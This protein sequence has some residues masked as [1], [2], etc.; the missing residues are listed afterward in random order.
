MNTVA[1]S[2]VRYSSGALEALKYLA[3]AS[4]VAD[5]VNKALFDSALTWLV[6]FGRLAFPIF[7]CLVGYNLARPSADYAKILRRLLVVAAIAT[8]FHPVIMGGAWLPLNVLTTF[9]VAVLIAWAIDARQY[10]VAIA[11][12]L[13]LPAFVDYQWSGVTLV[14]YAW[15]YA[16]NGTWP[17]AVG[18]LVSLAGV[19]LLV[20]NAWSFAALPVLLLA[21]YYAPAVPR[22]RWLFWAFYPAHLAVLYFS[23]R[24]VG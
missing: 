18:L 19:S 21:Q 15:R 6:P 12:G 9:A 13:F 11:M 14:L 17:A 7:A 4:M 10:P 5:H 20:G 24:L 22:L 1:V 2:R 16:G 8:P 23:A 3:L